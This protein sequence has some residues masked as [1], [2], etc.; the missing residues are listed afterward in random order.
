M[1]TCFV[2]T[3]EHTDWVWNGQDEESVATT[4]IAGVLFTEVDA[5]TYC[6]KRPGCAYEEIPILAAS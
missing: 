3:Y 2:I 5:K 1:S 6:A 4:V